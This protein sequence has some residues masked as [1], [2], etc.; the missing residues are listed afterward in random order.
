MTGHIKRTEVARR[1]G[2]SPRWVTR[3]AAEL[4]PVRLGHRTVWFPESE[5]ARYIEERRNR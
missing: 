5:V 4:K 2:V 1:L 3:I